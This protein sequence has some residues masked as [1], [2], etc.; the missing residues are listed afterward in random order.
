[1][2]IKKPYLMI[3]WFLPLYCYE[4]VSITE[5]GFES[6]IKYAQLS[7]VFRL[8][9]FTH[10][11]N[12]CSFVI[13]V[14]FVLSLLALNMLYSDITEFQL[15]AFLM[16]YALMTHL[17][18]KKNPHEIWSQYYLIC[19]VISWLTIIDLI[20]FFISGEFIISYRK[21]EV[22]GIGVPRINT[23]FDEM[24]HQAFFMMPATIFCSVYKSRARN[25]LLVGLLST[26]SVAALI[27][28]AMAL[29]IYL[30][31]KLLHNLLRVAPLIFIVTLALYL[32]SN[33][34]ISK[35][36]TVFVSDAL[37]TG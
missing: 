31:K 2:L 4:T 10:Q 21:P 13:S 5:I 9:L 15:V 11:I 8:L 20:S 30:R 19:V 33:F 6:F 26:M 32:G 28:F 12:N 36:S 27:L 17:I 25:L 24:S 18:T 34:I 1:M 14:L 22:I 35:M 7:L 37:V 16:G 3:F 29:L 23:I